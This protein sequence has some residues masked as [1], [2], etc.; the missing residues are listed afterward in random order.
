MSG[1][2]VNVHSASADLHRA[3]V[4]LHEDTEWASEGGVGRQANPVTVYQ[5]SISMHRTQ[6]VMHDDIDLGLV[7]HL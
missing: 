3:R 6:V 4:N 7:E 5:P 2:P 1:T